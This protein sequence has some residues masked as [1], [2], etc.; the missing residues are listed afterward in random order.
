M[1]DPHQ[2]AI[3]RVF[4]IKMATFRL[5]LLAVWQGEQQRRKE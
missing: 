1:L 5:K 3:L 4:N 2:V